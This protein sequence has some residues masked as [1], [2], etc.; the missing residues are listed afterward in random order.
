VGV[1]WLAVLFVLAWFRVPDPPTP[2][3]GRIPVPTLLA[4][5]GTVAGLVLAAVSRR[6][7]RRGARRRYRRAMAQ[8]AGAVA[9]TGDT[10]IVAPVERELQ[11]VA[12]LSAAVRAV[13]R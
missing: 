3:L 8:L 4:L 12:E 7:A 1:G 13:Q 11:A 2:E 9:D 5:G 6:L 10:L